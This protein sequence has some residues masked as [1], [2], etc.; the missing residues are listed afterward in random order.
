MA[1]ITRSLAVAS[2]AFTL[3]TFSACNDSVGPAEESS[4]GPEQARERHIPLEGQPN[5][6][7]I[8]GYET[9]DGRTVKWGQVYRSGQL[10]DLTDDDLGRLEA[11]GLRTVVTFLVPGEIER[12]G[13]DRLPDDVREL[14]LPITGE[15]GEQLSLEAL[16]AIKTGDFSAFPADISPE[17]HRLLVNDGR[18]V[19]AAL[20]RKLADPANLPL[21]YHCSHG[22]HRTGTATAIVLSALGVPW[23]TVREDYLLSNLYRAEEIEHEL[24]R[25]RRKV[26]SDRGVDPNDVDMT[27]V[28]AFYV[29]DGSYIDGTLERAIEDYGSMEGYIREGLGLT[30]EEI[31][32]LRSQLLEPVSTTDPEKGG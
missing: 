19:Y 29:L 30:D 8:G 9:A 4:S 7:D 1:V 23:E 14:H 11:I 27:N 25:I 31:A 24:E 2:I 32:F 18:E 17:L 3:L 21:A 16:T 5:F 20:L 28:E 26:A 13:A 12:Y 10:P 15:R 6:R 22:V